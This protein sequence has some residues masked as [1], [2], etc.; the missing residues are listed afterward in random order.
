MKRLLSVF[1]AAATCVMLAA[2]AW[3]ADQKTIGAFSLK[4]AEGKAVT[5]EALK[6][7]KTILVV[8]QMACRQCQM[9]LE[10]LKNM[11][12]DVQKK[13]QVFVVLVDMN[14]ENAL[15]KYK[16]AGHKATVLIDPDF[17][18]GSMAGVNVTPATVVVDENLKVKSAR[19]G[20]MPG[21]MED[22]LRDL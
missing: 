22:I 4:N 3:G 9:E 14:A 17:S 12:D 7:K 11:F 21:Q 16:K 1:A 20:Y 6:G 13:G 10:D 2:G 5:Q 15:E 19:T 8:A 18:L